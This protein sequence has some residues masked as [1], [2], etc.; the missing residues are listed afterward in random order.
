MKKIIAVL[1]ALI[2]LLTAAAFAQS[3][4]WLDV[5]MMDMTVSAPE[6]VMSFI[7]ETCYADVPF[8]AFYEDYDQNSIFNKNIAFAYTNEYIDIYAEDPLTFAGYVIE[9]AAES[10]AAQ[11]IKATTPVIIDAD[12]DSQDGRDALFMSYTTYVDYSALGYNMAF[13]MFAVQMVMPH[14]ESGITYI[15]TITTDNP[16]DSELLFRIADSIKWN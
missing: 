8:A 11:G 13:D 7:E 14:A 4:E 15:V 2:T 1:L 12:L 3:A 6:D 16:E 10:L 5:E 9:G